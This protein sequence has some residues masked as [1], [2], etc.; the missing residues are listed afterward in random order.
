[1]TATI[2]FTGDIMS[3]L[4]FVL[5]E[6]EG[7]PFGDFFTAP[8]RQLCKAQD[9]LWGNLEGPVSR[10]TNGL[11]I[12]LQL[13]NTRP[14]WPKLFFPRHYLATLLNLNYK[15]L[16]V[17][18]NHSLDFETT[19]D[20]RLSAEILEE[21]GIAAPGVTFDPVLRVV[22][23]ISFAI[24]ATTCFLNPP[25]HAGRVALITDQTKPQLLETIRQW[26]ARVD[27]VVV[28]THWGWDYIA[29]PTKAVRQLARELLDAGAR[30]IYGNHPHI[31]WP[32]EQPDAGRLVC[33]SMGNFAQVF[34][35][36]RAHPSFR[37]YSK[38][39]HGGFLS[40][41]FTRERIRPTFYPLLTRH[42]YE[43]WLAELGLLK[44]YWFWT[45]R[46][47]HQWKYTIPSR[48]QRLFSRVELNGSPRSVPL[49]MQEIDAFYI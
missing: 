7:R 20:A 12:H 21:H 19:A 18:N 37:P 15:V 11:E 27:Y 31:L 2:G 10:K 39:L 3:H 42:N 40:V 26:S 32:I 49:T 29:E 16:G 6:C 9:E 5:Q 23:G 33:Y 36:S 41:E 22:G 38:A 4:G 17:A 8:V 1:M 24:I 48:R 35:C 44:S 34:G 45:R 14:S 46:D 43:E 25:L 30:V 47:L 28:L 13:L